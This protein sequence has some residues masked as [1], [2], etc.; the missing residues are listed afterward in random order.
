MG[1][2]GAQRADERSGGWT[3]PPPLPRPLHACR[4]QLSLIA[5]AVHLERDRDRRQAR[6]TRWEG[7]NVQT[8]KRGTCERMSGIGIGDDPQDRTDRRG[9]LL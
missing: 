6:M 8:F 7:G 1:A 2:R 9:T 4:R 3:T 5:V